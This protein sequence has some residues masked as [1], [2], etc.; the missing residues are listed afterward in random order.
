MHNVWFYSCKTK[1]LVLRFIYTEWKR[2]SSLIFVNVNI[3]L[4][5]LWS[6]LEAMPLSHQYKYTLTAAVVP[7]PRSIT[8][9]SIIGCK[10]ACVLSKKRSFFDFQRMNIFTVTKIMRLEC[11]AQFEDEFPAWGRVSGHLWTLSRRCP[12]LR[13][14]VRRCP[15]TRTR[16]GNSSSYWAIQNPR[17]WMFIFLADGI[18]MNSEWYYVWYP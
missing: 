14:K 2:I 13:I 3:K 11:D 12:T 5:S 15:E 16:A 4:D 7:N 10:R 9:S 17:D 1:D 6:H 18:L 8:T